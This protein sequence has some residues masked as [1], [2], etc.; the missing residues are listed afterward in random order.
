M[1]ITTARI[2]KF[3][4]T[5]FQ[6]WKFKMQMVLEER[7]LWDVVSGEVKLEHCVST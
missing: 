1:P 3:A 7:Y 5:N 2:N 4:K 6:T